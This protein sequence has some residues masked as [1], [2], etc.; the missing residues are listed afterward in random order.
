MQVLGLKG[1][2]TDLY[3]DGNMHDQVS[4]RLLAVITT[5]FAQMSLQ[6]EDPRLRGKLQNILDLKKNWR[7]YRT[8]KLGDP[9]IGNNAL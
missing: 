2:I 1:F 6:Y 8:T 5:L 4:P 9:S 3:I 7:F